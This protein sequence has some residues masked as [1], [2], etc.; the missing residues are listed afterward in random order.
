MFSPETTKNKISNLKNLKVL[1]KFLKSLN[2]NLVFTYPNAD[3][4]FQD[5]I[6]IIK[7]YLSKK[8]NTYL[9]KNLGRKSIIN[10]LKY[11]QFL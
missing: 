5:Y 2:V 8:N 10:F 9:V 6:K 3:A 4:G 1:L 7:N 11:P